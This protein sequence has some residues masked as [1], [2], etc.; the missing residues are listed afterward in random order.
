[1]SRDRELAAPLPDLGPCPPPSLQ[2]LE[3]LTGKTVSLHEYARGSKATLLMVICNH[4]PF[5]V[6]LKP[7]LTQLAKEYQEKVG[8]RG[9]ARPSARAARLGVALAAAA[10]SASDPR[11]DFK[12]NPAPCARRRAWQ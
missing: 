11:P 6:H 12:I 1:L 5:V 2:L 9:R 4:C 7:A 8:R 10:S 3:P